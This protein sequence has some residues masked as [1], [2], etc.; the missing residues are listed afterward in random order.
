[1]AVSKYFS[2]SIPAMLSA[3]P[4]P[5]AMPLNT[6]VNEGNFHVDG[7]DET[8]AGDLA[9]RLPLHI[10][11]HIMCVEAEFMT[12]IR[13][14]FFIDEE[15][16]Q[17]LKALSGET[18]K[19]EGELIRES[20]AARI[21]ATAAEDDDWRNGLEKLSRAWADRDD[22][23]GFVRALRKGSGRRLARLGLVEKGK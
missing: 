5:F 6:S 16:N 11:T 7:S 1:M 8:V 4:G 18:G 14:Q 3:F 21:E 20:I 13:K 10:P 9:S 15:Q 19:S 23:Q 22:M 12:M 2:I 17:R